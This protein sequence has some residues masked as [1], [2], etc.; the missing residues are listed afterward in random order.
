[1]RMVLCMLKVRPLYAHGAVYVPQ[2]AGYSSY[3]RIKSD[4]FVIIHIVSEAKN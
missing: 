3:I 2:A 1:M 4:P